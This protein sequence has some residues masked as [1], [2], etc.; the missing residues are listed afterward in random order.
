MFAN[1]DPR[2]FWHKIAFYNF[3]QRAMLKNKETEEN[4]R[5]SKMDY[6]IAWEV[7]FDVVK[8]IKP[9][10]CLFFGVSM[11]EGFNLAANKMGLKDTYI[12]YGDKINGAYFK[13]S[14]ITINNK[15][16]NLYFIKHPSK[17]FSADKW[18]EKLKSV[19]PSLIE[20]LT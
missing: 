9:E 4:E 16:V 10:N 5:P 19:N 14:K 11:V 18:I 17:Y 8:V 7:F 2:I 12:Q 3:I 15:N 13:Y 20:S 1:G 6:Q